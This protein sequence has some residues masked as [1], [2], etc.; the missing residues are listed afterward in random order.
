MY[1]S[2][3]QGKNWT[4]GITVDHRKA[5]YSSMCFDAKSGKVFLLFECGTETSVDQIDVAEF[6]PDEILG[7]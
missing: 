4:K 5:A 1:Y 6:T 3:D 7:Q 2:L